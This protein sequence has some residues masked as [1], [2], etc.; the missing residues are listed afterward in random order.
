[1]FDYYTQG[2][3]EDCYTI[4]AAAP[5]SGKSTL[6]THIALGFLTRNEGA[7]KPLILQTEALESDA[8]IQMAC[9]MAGVSYFSLLLGRLTAEQ[10]QSVRAVLQSGVLSQVYIKTCSGYSITQI[11]SLMRIHQ[12]RHGLPLVIVD[13]AADL[14]SGNP[15]ADE[16]S[17][18]VSIS[19]EMKRLKTQYKTHIIACVHLRKKSIGESPRPTP[20][21]IKGTGQWMGDADCV[22][23]LYRDMEQVE[24][25]T[26]LRIWKQ[27]KTPF[28]GHTIKFG[29][30][31]STGQLEGMN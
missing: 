9:T 20:D 6:C 27:R 30:N 2:V 5:S 18:L 11:E 17:R 25:H 29:Y 15:A 13:M 12:R 16:V 19:R 24:G 4:L 7:G 14:N 10:K 3:R 31:F 1:M 22:Y 23:T 26:E 21:D 8:A 28:V